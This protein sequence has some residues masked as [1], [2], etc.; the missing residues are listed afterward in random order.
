MGLKT[1]EPACT[2][3]AA[4]DIRSQVR[5][6]REFIEDDSNDPL[7]KRVAQIKED[8]LRWCIEAT[9]WA[10]PVD[11]MGMADIIRNELDVNECSASND[12]LSDVSVEE[13]VFFRKS[14]CLV[15]VV[16]FAGDRLVVEKIGGK[17]MI[18]TRDGVDK[19]GPY[20]C[21]CQT[22]QGSGCCLCEVG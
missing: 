7:E 10:N 11:D 15:T 1:K 17:R 12:L 9:T 4:T 3:P 16:G 5:L 2:K 18:A 8:S 21:L 6:L 13:Q 22:L 14:G 20:G 19:L